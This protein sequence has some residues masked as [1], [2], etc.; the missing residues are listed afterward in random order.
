M[1]LSTILRW[2]VKC[3]HRASESKRTQIPR[4]SLALG[5]KHGHIFRIF[6]FEV[7]LSFLVVVIYVDSE[8]CEFNAIGF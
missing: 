4:G 2:F 7:V 8:K 1:N 6:L 3:P 5:V